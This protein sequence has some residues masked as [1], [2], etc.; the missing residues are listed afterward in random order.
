MDMSFPKCFDSSQQ[1]R[2]WS[3]A[4][5]RSDPGDSSFCTDCTA[6]YQMQM[7]DQE[8]CFHP[9]TTFP[10]GSRGGVDGRRPEEERI[11]YQE[12]A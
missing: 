3:Q 8:R 11:G 12:V 7:I 4:A 9:G 6:H 2:E 1:F 5:K 10:V